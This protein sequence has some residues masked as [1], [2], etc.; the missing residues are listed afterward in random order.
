MHKRTILFAIES[1]SIPFCNQY[2]SIFDSQRVWLYSIVKGYYIEKKLS[3][4]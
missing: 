2:A 1:R 4:C 3:L